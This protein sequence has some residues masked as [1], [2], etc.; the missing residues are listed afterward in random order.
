MGEAIVCGERDLDFSH[1]RQ[2]TMVV[3]TEIVFGEGYLEGFWRVVCNFDAPQKR[4]FLMF[5]TGGD[6]APVGGLQHL[7]LK[8]QRNVGE[9][10]MRLP[11]AHTCFNL[12]MLPEYDNEDKLRRLLLTAM[13]NAEG[14]GLE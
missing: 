12:L 13:E 14:F 2:G 11:T 1:L 4:Q 10:T 5:V 7:E 9:P 3:E 6:L 8:L